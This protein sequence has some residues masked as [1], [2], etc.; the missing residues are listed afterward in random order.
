[1]L[2]KQGKIVAMSNGKEFL[3]LQMKKPCDHLF[4]RPLLQQLMNV[5][6][7]CVILKVNKNIYKIILSASGVLAPVLLFLVYS[8]I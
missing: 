6:Q 8:K 7:D 2:T 3:R 1:M 4:M 5:T